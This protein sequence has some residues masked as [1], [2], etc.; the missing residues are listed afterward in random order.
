MHPD[1]THRGSF[2]VDAKNHRSCTALVIAE[3]IHIGGNSIK[4]DTTAAL[5]RKLGAEPS[6]PDIS[7]EPDAR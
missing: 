4:S 2:G 7:R 3:G 5:L 6:P 1:V